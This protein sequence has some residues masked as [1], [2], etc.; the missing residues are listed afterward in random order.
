MAPVAIQ[1]VWSMRAVA[2]AETP[3]AAPRVMTPDERMAAMRFNINT[4]HVWAEDGEQVTAIKEGREPTPPR[5][6][7]RRLTE[8]GRDPKSWRPLMSGG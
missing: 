1:S 6:A 4:C 5:W 7:E 8:L 3:V 2:G